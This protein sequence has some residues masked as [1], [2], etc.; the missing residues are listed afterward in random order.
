MGGGVLVRLATVMRLRHHLT[1]AHDDGPDGNL[2]LVARTPGLGKG[3]AHVLL[4]IYRT[5]VQFAHP[6]RR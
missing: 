5:L 2:A 3:D 4:V 6:S 1:V